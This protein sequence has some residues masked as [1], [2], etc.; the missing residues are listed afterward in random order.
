MQARARGRALRSSREQYTPFKMSLDESGACKPSFFVNNIP[1]RRHIR[2]SRALETQRRHSASS[3]GGA[4]AQLGSLLAVCFHPL[5]H[6]NTVNKGIMALIRILWHL[7]QCNSI[8]Y[9][10]F[11]TAYHAYSS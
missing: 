6:V 9:S 7:A 11:V 4:G 8:H 2:A 10:T 3:G 1:L 5:Q